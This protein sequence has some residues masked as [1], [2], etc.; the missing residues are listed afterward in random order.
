MLPGGDDDLLDPFVL[1][2]RLDDREHLDGLGR[3]PTTTRTRGVLSGSSTTGGTPWRESVMP[4][5]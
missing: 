5:D 2:Q 3:V 4:R 1:A